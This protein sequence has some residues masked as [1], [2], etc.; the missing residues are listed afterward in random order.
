MKKFIFILVV[1][2]ALLAASQAW[3]A[4]AGTAQDYLVK[5]NE[6]FKAG[7]LDQ[8]I[9]DYT[10]ALEIDPKLAWAYNNLGAIY[11]QKDDFDHAMAAYNKALE[12]DPK[13]AQFYN[14]RGGAYRELNHYDEAIADFKRALELNP[15]YANAY[16]NRAVAYYAKKDFDKAWADVNKAQ[17]LG[18]KIDPKFLEGLRKASGREK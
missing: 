13:Q 11:V 1:L 5:G 10:K 17:S 16:Y 4:E 9:A 15:S 14:N 7:N 2:A 8:A 3:A 6:Q 12:I 18:A